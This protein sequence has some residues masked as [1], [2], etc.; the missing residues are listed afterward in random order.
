MA[1]HSPAGRGLE[2]PPKIGLMHCLTSRARGRANCPFSDGAFPASSLG[3]TRR[4]AKAAVPGLANVERLLL[5]TGTPAHLHTCAAA[6]AETQIASGPKRLRPI[7]ATSVR[8]GAIGVRDGARAGRRMIGAFA[9]IMLPQSRLAVI[10]HV[11]SCGAERAGPVFISPLTF[12]HASSAFP[13]AA[14][15]PQVDSRWIEVDVSL[16]KIASD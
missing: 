12:V 14:R 3:P 16:T 8:G 11:N 1:S 4:V 9:P 7:T 2:T 13:S 10:R 5:Q 6:Q 15:P